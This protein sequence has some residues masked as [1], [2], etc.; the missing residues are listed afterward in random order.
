MKKK[1]RD[2][3]L[4]SLLCLGITQS[5]LAQNVTVKGKVTDEKGEMIPGAS[6][7]VKGSQQGTLTDAEGVYSIDVAGNATLVFSFLGYLKEEVAVSNRSTI[8]VSLKT[9]TKALEEVVV[10]GY[11]TQR[12]VETTGSIA[13]VK[14]EDLV[15]TPVANIAQGLQARVAGVQIN[16]NSGSPGGNI[17]VR[18]RGTNSINGSSEPLYVI[19]GIQISNG[20]GITDVSPLSTINPNDIE[21]VEVLKDASA[22]AIYGARAANGVI[23][24]TT[25]RGKNGTTRVTYDGYYG[26]QKVNKTLDVLNASQFA[27]LENEVFKN[28][29][30]PDPASLGEGV[31]WQKLIFRKAPIQNH[32][33]SINGG[34]E[35]TQL[36]ISLNYFDQDGTL[37]GSQ[38]QRYSYRLNLDHRIS[39]NVKVGTSILGSY[40]I[41]N[42]IQTGGT[43]IGDGGAVLSS[44][45]GAAIGAPPTLQPYR[46]DGSIFPFGEQAGGQYREVVNPLNF[47]AVLNKRSIK[48]TLAN[49]YGEVSLFK[50]LT[51][52]ASF[53]IDQ[54]GEL[55]DGY[56][57][58]SIVNK[59][60]LNDNSGSGTKANSNYL[61][62]LHESIL[63]YSTTFAKNHSFKATAVFGTQ[64]EQG[65]SNTMN[66]TG[67]PNDATRNE[68]MQL[69]LTRTISSGRSSQRLDSYMARVNYGFK[70]KFF[71]DVTARAD[72]SSKFGAN[73]KYGVFP[74][75]SAAYRIIEEPFMKDISWLSDF[76][77]RGSYGITGNAGGIDPYQSLA[78]VASGNSYMINHTYVTGIEPT[79]I[80]NPDLRWERSK[81]ANIGVDISLLNNRISIIADVYHKKTDDLLYVKTLPLSSGYGAITGNFAALQNKGLELAVN[82]RILDGK[83]KWDVSANATINRN[84]VL[85][86]DGGITTERFMTTYTILKVGQ[87][88]GMFKTYVF[89]GVNQTGETI[90][91]GYDGRLGGHKVKDVTGDGQITAADQVIVGNPNPKFIYGFSTNLSYAGFDLAAFVSGSQGND[92]YNAS[93][94]S[95]EN[96]LGQRNL[97]AG[98]A[99]RWSPTNPSNQYVS[100][101][102]GGRLPISNYVVENGSYLRCKNL[103]LGYTVPR[104]KGVQGIRLYV[105][106]NNL[107]TITKYSGY[108]PEVNTYAGSNTVIGVDNFVYPQSKSFLG[109]IQVTF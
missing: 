46:A 33:L 45:L 2:L 82:A 28:N 17:S 72:G 66:A 10:V 94:L 77:L 38:F 87:P 34:S 32:Q 51:Y 78:T 7:T 71:I 23:L 99:N 42:G 47:S 9:D 61:A 36:A 35:K 104:F 5:L 55:F 13:S 68:A 1:I 109:G 102:Q 97:L 92:I 69:A 60:D 22:S 50:G 56:S 14:A 105:S 88:L 76:K 86:L 8:D 24:I 44:V 19:D 90:L 4:L 62:L 75:V 108:D 80:A 54:K 98:V 103:T 96:P 79:G 63:T 52:R 67:F 93:R 3:F 83:L 31:N 37:I 30:Y 65:N 20:G 58:R 39:K 91:P 64:L 85:G 29:Y 43:N 84:K 12:K 18:I 73:H 70:D 74:A 27:Q 59:S 107:F 21:S 53:N 41:S 48:R 26:S 16:Q 81:Q 95:F 15:Q 100:G 101:F 49:I 40:S 25:K 106:A 57:P 89:D 6:V 11:G